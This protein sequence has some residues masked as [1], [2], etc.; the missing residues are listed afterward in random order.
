VEPP[1]PAHR[2]ARTELEEQL[3]AVR[4][5]LSLREDAPSGDWVESTARE[6]AAGEKPGWAFPLS[7]G[8]G[9][10]FYSRRRREAFG[11]VHAGVGTDLDARARAL[12]EVL[13]DHLTDA[14]DSANLG[15]TGLEPGAE[16]DV[17]RRLAVRPGSTS[18][19]RRSMER[20]LSAADAGPA[21]RTPYPLRLVPVGEV[22]VE[23]IADL[24]RRAFA[25]TI[26]ATLLGEGA[27]GAKD[28]IEA[29]LA[30]RLGRFVDE[31]STALVESDPVRLVAAVLSTEQ[32]IRR[33]VLVDLMVD[34]ERR[35]RGVG[36]YLLVWALRALW[37]LGYESVRLWVTDEN[38]AAR[39]LYDAF[40]FRTIGSATLYRWDRPGP[41][42]AAHA[43]SGR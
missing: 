12:G 16:R 31:A 1:R 4:R 23:A 8:G 11:H 25:G 36:R 42:S 38:R 3:Q 35:R 32:S 39:G 27:E 40:G 13:L 41:G 5:A 10:A 14:V 19:P 28:A 33:A 15:F 37:A 34:P 7:D 24:D 18:I 26:D 29:M 2:I 20:A 30:G 21:P 43:H 9:I 22:T 17:V 6:L